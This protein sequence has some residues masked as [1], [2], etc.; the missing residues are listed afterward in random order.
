MSKSPVSEVAGPG[1]ARQTTR[2][3]HN[4]LEK[5][6]RAHLKSCFNDLATECE[7]E[8]GKA[9]NLLV[10]RTAY[11]AIMA[12][13]REEREQER[14]LAALVQEKVRRQSYLNELRRETSGY[15]HTSD[16]E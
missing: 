13:R 14:T 8:A 15:C 4:R 10:I 11:K 7:L 9:S 5:N 1:Q 3:V 6:R 2:E 12:L 16:S